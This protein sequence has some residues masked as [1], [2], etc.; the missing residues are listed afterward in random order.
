M[1]KIHKQQM[2]LEANKATSGNSWQLD[3][4]QYVYSA[5]TDVVSQSGLIVLIGDI[6]SCTCNEIWMHVT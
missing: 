1:P 2:Y 3:N 6:V 5:R 4:E